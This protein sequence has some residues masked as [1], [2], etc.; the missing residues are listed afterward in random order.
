MTATRPTPTA[1]SVKMDTTESITRLV[2]SMLTIALHAHRVRS[3]QLAARSVT[4]LLV[5]S[6]CLE[7]KA[8]HLTTLTLTLLT[9]ALL[10]TSARKVL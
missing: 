5:T 2:T 8:T 9:P 10:A 4:V 3:A 7:L 1:S 6:A